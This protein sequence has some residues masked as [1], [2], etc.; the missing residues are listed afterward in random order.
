MEG[1]E[2]KLGIRGVLGCFI[3]WGGQSAWKGWTGC[4]VPNGPE[5]WGGKGGWM[6]GS[7]E[8]VQAPALPGEKVLAS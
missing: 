6:V 2:G 1:W 5:E 3:W 7:Y 4:W 8:D